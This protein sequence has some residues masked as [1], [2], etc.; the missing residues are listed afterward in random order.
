MQ[1][2]DRR[3][4]QNNKR[5]GYLFLALAVVLIIMAVAAVLF[6]YVLPPQKGNDGEMHDWFGRITDD[7]PP[8]LNLILPHWAGHIWLIIDCLILLAMIIL[9]DRMFVKSKLY[10][11]GIKNVDF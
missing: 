1:E 3:E 6:G 11:T 4:Q 7:I 8:A 10:F 9:I 5:M 2:F